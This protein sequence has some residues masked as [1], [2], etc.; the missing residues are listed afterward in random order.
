MGFPSEQCFK[1][2]A[3]LIAA[4]IKC[5]LCDWGRKGSVGAE[6]GCSGLHPPPLLPPH[7]FIQSGQYRLSLGPPAIANLSM[8]LLSNFLDPRWPWE[9]QTCSPFSSLCRISPT[10]STSLGVLHISVS[11]TK[12]LAHG[13]VFS[14][15]KERTWYFKQVNYVLCPMV[16]RTLEKSTLTRRYGNVGLGGMAVYMRELSWF[17]FLLL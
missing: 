2:V 5:V 1:H 16:R 11:K 12:F 14:R 7:F 8:S 4:G 6:L 10:P 9:P 13:P 17:L 3:M 15:G